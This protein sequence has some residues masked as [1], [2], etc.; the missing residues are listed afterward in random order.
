MHSRLFPLFICLAII[1]TQ[2]AAAQI[3]PSTLYSTAR[4]DHHELAL[5]DEDWHWL[6]HKLELKIGAVAQESAP[7]SVSYNDGRY[8]GITA[9]ISAL[10][11][12]LLGV[13]IKLV[14]FQTRQE[15]MQAL[16]TGTIDFVGS[17]NSGHSDN[18]IRHTR[19]F[20]EG[21]LALFKRSD[22]LRNAPRDLAGLRVAVPE[23][24]AAE[25]RAH[26]PLAQLQVQASHEQ[27]ITATAFG[28]A[29]LYVDDVLSAYFQ[30]NRSY[31][32]FLR[33]ERFADHPKGEYGFALKGNNERLQRILDQSIE[34]IGQE[35]L[36]A[37]SRR[38]VGSGFV[39]SD[40]RIALTAQEARWI[41]RNPVLRLLINDDL[42]PVAFF[43]ANGVF[44]GVAAELLEVIS[45]RTGLQFQV[46]ARNGGYPEQI[47]ALRQAEADLAIMTA[48]AQREEKLR[49]TRPFLTSPFVLVTQVDKT[50]RARPPGNLAGKR[51]AIPAGH[52]LRQQ[53]HELYPNTEL[54][55]TQTSLDSMNKVY[56]GDADAAVVSLPTSRYYIVRL[57]Q[58][59]LGIADLIHTNQKTANFALRLEDSELQSILDKALLSLPADDLNAMANHWR[60]PPGMSGETWRDYTIVI[61]EIVTGASLLLLMSLI[62]GFYLQ[63]RVRVEKNLNDQLRLLETLT[64]NMPPVL[65]IRDIAG[66]ML[67]CNRSY[68][69][70]VGL[71]AEQVLN[72]TVQQLPREHFSA[73][74][75]LHQRYLQAINDGQTLTSVEAVRLQG[76]NIWIEH[77]I[78]PFQ[79]AHGVTKGVIC[80]WLDI[81]KHRHLV[82]ELKEAKDLADDASRAKT[83]FLATMSHEIRTPMNAVISILELELKRGDSGRI[84]HSSI[85]IAYSSAKSLLELI[86]DILDIA[87]IESGRLSLSPKRANLRELVESVARVFEGLARQKCLSLVLEIDSSINGD[88]L[89]DGMR[90]KQILSNLVSNAIKFTEA[91][92]VKVIIGADLL[93]NSTLR[94]KLSVEDSGIGISPGNQQ[95]LFQ[96]FSQVER[97]VQHTEGTGLGLVICRSLCEMMGGHISLSSSL[98]H[99]TRVDVELQLQVLERV[100]TPERPPQPKAR[101]MYRL[102][103][104]VVD[105]HAVNRQVLQQQLCFLGHDVVEAE[106]GLDA[107]NI[108]R[109]R[110]FDMIITDHHM[111]IMN[112]AELARAI[113]RYER[114]SISQPVM[115]IGLTADAQPE[116]VERCIQAGMNDCLVKPIGL[117]ELEQRLLSIGDIDDGEAEPSLPH[118]DVLSPRVFDLESLQTL[119]GSEPKMLRH[120]LSELIVNNRTDQQALTTCLQKQ[121][122]VELAELA[123]RIKGA[124]R[125]VKGEQ[126]VESCHQL[127]QACLNLMPLDAV[128]EYVEQVQHAIV[129]L[130]QGLLAQQ[131]IWETPPEQ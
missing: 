113:R 86:G 79:D 22:E 24:H 62:W 26:F 125:V 126:L 73:D 15:A 70:S 72:K 71:S 88:V 93:E 127:E 66:N 124:A 97:N 112:G 48:S 84:E 14:P 6:R 7:F 45:Q 87:R 82:Q 1:G 81:T 83:T 89:V 11:G 131:G 46:T 35:K 9:D 107:L 33:F 52:V 13:R 64:E 91:G 98:G 61:A 65:Y 69:D 36:V 49:F 38:W 25:L 114:D 40:D 105:D 34:A 60:S 67:C 108:W 78:Q 122:T 85:E 99:G 103:V 118:S 20:A 74:P 109:E 76:K 92:F 5:E 123:H 47:E 68:L 21:R 12:Q 110:G 31:Y 27:A 4:L 37:L 102:Q 94:V 75:S 58:N 100:V 16:Q 30:I 41:E 18:S 39:P 29:D 57:F 116:E 128:A 50:G 10:I 129:T 23:E 3:L 104:L 54:I 117:D 90:F 120:I 32:G 2:S 43:D 119:V 77:W 44:S 96:P 8:E 17:Y 121:A 42:A 53:V 115:I 55:E 28:H 95:R 101:H 59:R 130:E 63:R 51:L 106:N 56:A 80:G 111:P 19:P